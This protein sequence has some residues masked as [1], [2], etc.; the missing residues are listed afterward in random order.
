MEKVSL[1]IP[2]YNAENTIKECLESVIRQSYEIDEI[3]VID[4]GSKDKTIE[5]AKQYPV[6]I[7]SHKENKGLAASRNTA[8]REANNE[9]VAAL[10]ADCIASPEW[11]WQLMECFVNDGIVGAGGMLAE[12]YT[13]SMAD[14][15]RS[16][17]MAQHWGEELLENPP[18]L[19]GNNTVF[20]KKSVEKVSFYNEK[21]KTNYED[22]DLSMR[23]YNCGISLIYNP[24]A[25]V[26]HMRKDT[27][28]SVLST[29]RNWFYY[30]HLNLKHINQAS[31]RVAMN[32][33]RIAEYPEIFEVFF[34]EDLRARNYELLPL[35]FVLIP[36]C[37]WLDLRQLFKI[38][39]FS[40]NSI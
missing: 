38:L 31:R 25:H 33:G 26:E 16:V 5:I 17:H 28:S 14:K 9:F 15:W 29:Y 11:L 39:F 18:F 34:R 2:C 7:I 22:I 30:A 36:Y 13:L 23:I 40:K 8:F 20:R 10:D 4:D 35:D 1:Y 3:L 21:Y 24:K 6:R 37:T 32:L 27:M 19:Y 12:R